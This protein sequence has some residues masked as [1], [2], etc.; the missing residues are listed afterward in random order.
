MSRASSILIFGGYCDRQT[1]SSL[2]AKYT[3]DKWEE[4]GHLQ[5]PRNTHRAISNGDRIY[6]VGGY[7][8]DMRCE[9]IIFSID[10]FLFL[11]LKSGR[12]RTTTEMSI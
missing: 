1:D 9:I 2:I 4:V 3:L 5:Q 8:N 12:S 11:A 7:W 6:V 10:F